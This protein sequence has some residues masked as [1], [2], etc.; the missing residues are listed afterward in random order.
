MSQLTSLLDNAYVSGM[1]EDLGF[2]GNQLV[3]LQMIFTVGNVLG[4]LPFAH[5]F[6][7]VPMHW[8]VPAL[9][10]GWGMF[11]LIQYRANSLA[12]LMAYRFM[13]SIFE[14]CLITGLEILQL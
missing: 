5:L 7:K 6:P 13:V 2:H 4:L 9:D 14:V 11:T 12:E 10:L 1:S 8:L 3:E